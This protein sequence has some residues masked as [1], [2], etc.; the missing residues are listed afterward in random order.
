MKRQTQLDWL[1]S[2]DPWYVHDNV[3]GSTKVDKDYSQCG[4]WLLGS[5][6]YSQWRNSSGPAILYLCGT[7]KLLLAC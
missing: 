4:Q 1:S 7:G 2:A 3:L 5:N 6:E